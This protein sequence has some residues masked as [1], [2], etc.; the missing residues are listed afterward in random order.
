M[1]VHS[2]GQAVAH[3][4]FHSPSQHAN[5]INEI[6]SPAFVGR[7]AWNLALEQLDLAVKYRVGRLPPK[8]HCSSYRGVAGQEYR[9]M[10]SL[11]LIVQDLSRSQL[12]RHVRR[13]LSYGRYGTR[14][15]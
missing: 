8:H 4:G 7:R 1:G 13:R 5:K 3:F 2:G 10:R 9:V 12:L 11:R 14:S 15:G 6:A